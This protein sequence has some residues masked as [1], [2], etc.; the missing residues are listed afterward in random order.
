[1]KRRTSDAI[2]VLFGL[3]FLQHNCVS[4]QLRTIFLQR[5]SKSFH[6]SSPRFSN[7]GYIAFSTNNLSLTHCIPYEDNNWTRCMFDP[8]TRAPQTPPSIRVNRCLIDSSP[9]LNY[10]FSPA[11]RVPSCFSFFSTKSKVTSY[12]TTHGPDP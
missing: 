3:G 1:M 4:A 7:S 6:S 9:P 12:P 11:P 2:V 8:N 5:L 10:A